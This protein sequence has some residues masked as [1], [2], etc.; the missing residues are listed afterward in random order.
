[1]EV[2]RHEGGQDRY[3]VNFCTVGS[4]DPFDDSIE[5]KF[6]QLSINYEVSLGTLVGWLDVAW[7]FFPRLV[8]SF[9]VSLDRFT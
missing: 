7:T 9:P 1:M 5:E 8:A 6:K 3:A 4:G 2:R